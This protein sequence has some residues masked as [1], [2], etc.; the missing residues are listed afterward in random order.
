[1]RT[2]RL[3]LIAVATAL[4]LAWVCA[5]PLP[6]SE[7]KDAHG[8]KAA[9]AGHDHEAEGE[10]SPP[11]F[12]PVR[13]DL[14]IW[15]LVVFLL[16]LFVLTKYAWNPMLG[17]LHRREENIHAAIEESKRAREEA[18]NLRE[19]LASERAK[20]ADE[21]RVALDVA[22]RDSQQL[23]ETMRDQAKADTQ[24]DRA[25]LRRENE[26]AKDQAP[27]QKWAQSD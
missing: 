15:T 5:G 16:L 26:T 2:S 20:I 10:K 14:A 4:A 9:T 21:T 12:T 11:I 13:I 19:H 23:R 22:R 1:M 7:E 25:R 6:A 24:A 18:R 17:A 3:L 8:G 27:K